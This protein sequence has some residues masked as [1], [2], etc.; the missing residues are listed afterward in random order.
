MMENFGDFKVKIEGKT[1]KDHYPEGELGLAQDTL[2][3]F[4]SSYQERNAY[5]VSQLPD[6]LAKYILV[7]PFLNCGT[8]KLRLLEANLWLSSGGTKSLLHRD[9]DNAINCLLNGTK[10]WV[11]IDPA[12]EDLIP[13]AKEDVEAYGGFSLLNPDSVDL[14]KYPQFKGVPWW[15]ANMTAGDCLFLP[16][17]YW[18]QVRSYGTKNMA[19]SVLFS[20]LKEVDLEECD[21]IQPEFIALSDSQM[22]F[23]Y[24]GFGDQTMGN[25]DPFELKETLIEV[26]Q[27]NGKLTAATIHETLLQAYNEFEETD[28]QPAELDSKINKDI[29]GQMMTIL[30]GSNKG[31]VSCDVIKGLTLDTMTLLADVMDNDPA[32]TES[33]EY[34]RYEARDIINLVSAVVEEAYELNDG[35]VTSQMFI[36]Q[37]QTI[38]GSKKVAKEIFSPESKRQR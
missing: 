36:D 17:G 21:Q 37:Y 32:N 28:V 11:L 31:E 3:H 22:V 2:R 25:T 5:I 8:F 1:E 9:A 38:G 18:H 19:V 30:G 15:Y 4:L 7:M 26:C 20:R 29:S 27:E 14:E 34:A 35:I 24:D 12:F 6:P 10:D 23:R 13:I 33:Y 16:Y